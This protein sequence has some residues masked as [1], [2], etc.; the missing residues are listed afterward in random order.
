MQKSYAPSNS[1]L[2][3]KLTD[4]CFQQLLVPVF[5]LFP[6]PLLALLFVLLLLLLLLLRRRRGGG[7]R[8]RAGRAPAA[9]GV[10]VEEEEEEEEVKGEGL[11]GH[12]NIERKWSHNGN[13]IATQCRCKNRGARID[14]IVITT[15]SVRTL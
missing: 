2:A 5:R 10:W 12:V 8:G 6:L 11:E 7:G 4:E 9:A 14:G 13:I 15:V 1:R 3:F